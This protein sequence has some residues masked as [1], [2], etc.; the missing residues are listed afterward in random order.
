M[1]WSDKAVSPVVYTPGAGELALDSGLSV[2]AGKIE[3]SDFFKFL[4]FVITGGVTSGNY[5]FSLLEYSDASGIISPRNMTGFTGDGFTVTSSAYHSTQFPWLVFD[6][7]PSTY[8]QLYPTA[9]GHVTLELP[10]KKRLTGFRVQWYSTLLE[11]RIKSFSVLG[12]NSGAFSGEEVILSTV[13]DAKY[14]LTGSSDNSIVALGLSRT[15]SILTANAFVPTPPAKLATLTHVNL[16]LDT[17]GADGTVALYLQHY[18]DIVARWESY[19]GVVDGWTLAGPPASTTTMY[20]L[21]ELP[22]RNGERVRAKFVF[23]STDGTA[24]A[25][26]VSGLTL[27]WTSDVSAPVAPTIASILG[28][29]GANALCNLGPVPA[30]ARHLTAEV[31]I[32]GAGFLPLS[33]RNAV[34]AGHGYLEYLGPVAADEPA[35]GRNTVQVL[36]ENLT[37]GQT[38]QVRARAVDAVGNISAASDSELLTLEDAVSIPALYIEDAVVFSGLT[39]NIRVHLLGVAESQVTVDYASADGT[40]VSPDD[41]AA[42]S[43]IASFLAD[44]DVSHQWLDIP[45]N[46]TGDDPQSGTLAYTVVLSSPTG[47]TIER[48]TGNVTLK[49]LDFIPVPSQSVSGKIREQKYKFAV[50]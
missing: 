46:A 17:T 5:I 3:F 38:V 15:A 32:D 10:A 11:Y 14:S 12:S 48:A 20:S 45:I 31:D 18:N 23:T 37:Q 35:G 47:A 34:E 43:G 2:V 19:D 13:A 39:A 30:D 21:D 27:S 29:G 36:V 33:K 9:V 24:T 25:P 44:P 50:K 28:V 22:A 26:A 16:T 4:R 6:G 8:A 1:P 7:N 40:A 42:F 49:A 41:F